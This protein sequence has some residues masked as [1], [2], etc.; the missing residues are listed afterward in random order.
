MK[1]ACMNEKYRI[2][3]ISV[4][5]LIFG[6][7]CDTKYNTHIQKQKKN[8]FTLSFI[9]F[10]STP[11][12]A[13]FCC[14]FILPILQPF[15]RNVSILYSHYTKAEYSICLNINMDISAYVLNGR[16]IGAY[17]YHLKWCVVL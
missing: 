11:K 7:I 12:S 5:Y 2:R 16:N 17:I 8:K 15:K 10:F 13:D 4:L 9:F 6:M 14:M 1:S 3:N